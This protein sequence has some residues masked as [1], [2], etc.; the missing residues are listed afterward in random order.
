TQK[1]CQRVNSPTTSSGHPAMKSVLLAGIL[2][3][4]GCA[5][6]HIVP[7]PGGH[8]GHAITKCLS[9][10]ACVRKARRVC[11]GPFHVSDPVSESFR[12]RSHGR[13]GEVD[14]TMTVMCPQE[15]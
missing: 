11:G 12:P 9:A 3:C 6:T 13:F 10:A 2:L 8:E 5:A 4:S 7:L 1:Q 15:R 14:Y